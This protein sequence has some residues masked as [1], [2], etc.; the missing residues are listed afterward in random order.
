MKNLLLS[1]TII[2]FSS[3]LSAQWT[4]INPVTTNSNVGIGTNSPSEQL[5]IGNVNNTNNYK[6]SIP[7]VYNFENI[8]L[9]Q[10]GNGACGLEFVNHTNVSNSYG[11]RFF[12]NVDNG[13]AGLQIQ[14][15]SP[16]SSY[17]SL[18]YSTAM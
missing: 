2:T 5:Q 4:G 1:L 8:K 18:S 10:Y 16:T 11:V 6:I 9:G 15:A 3:L 17:T 12:S 13:I 14:V 7:G